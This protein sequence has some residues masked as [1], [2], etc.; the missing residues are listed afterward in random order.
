MYEGRKVK[1]A[2]KAQRPVDI[3]HDLFHFTP[4][5]RCPR[6]LV[7]GPLMNCTS[8]HATISATYLPIF[9]IPN[10]TL[11]ALYPAQLLKILAFSFI[12]CGYVSRIHGGQNNDTNSWTGSTVHPSF[13][14]S[15][16]S[17]ISHSLM[18]QRVL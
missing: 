4:I 13:N 7:A 16:W 18:L 8:D 11:F 9:C 1:I 17:H 2:I 5:R 15:L 10:D 12:G 3:M 6:H 14:G